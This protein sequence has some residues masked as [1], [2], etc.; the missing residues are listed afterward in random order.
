MALTWSGRGS[1]IVWFFPVTTLNAVQYTFR[2]QSIA[3]TFTISRLIKVQNSLNVIQNW[4]EIVSSKLIQRWFWS[5]VCIFEAYLK[6]H[7]W[8]FG[9]YLIPFDFSFY[10]IVSLSTRKKRTYLRCHR[11]K[12][13]F[14]QNNK[15][16]PRARLETRN[17]TKAKRT[18]A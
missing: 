9:C 1:C 13:P 18:C 14:F 17:E 16:P 7:C 10:S 5:T 6:H 8:P 3:C 15:W 4:L 11:W 12:Q 2:L